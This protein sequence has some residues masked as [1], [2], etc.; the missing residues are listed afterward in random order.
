M[1]RNIVGL[2]IGV[3]VAVLILAGILLV[4]A[5]REHLDADKL[6]EVASA[7]PTA[8]ATGADRFRSAATMR[9]PRPK[10][11]LQ[12]PEV[13]LGGGDEMGMMRIG[14]GLS[15]QQI[16]AS[17]GPYHSYLANCQP[18]DGED[19]SGSVTF[20]LNV[21]CDGVVHGVEVTDDSLYEPEMIACLRDRLTYV[22]FPAHDLEDGMYFEYPLIFHPPSL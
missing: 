14:E 17:F 5:V 4:P 1:R 6:Q 7:V 21:G 20:E 10:K 8:G 15:P 16:N 22:E 9:K 2:V 19:H 11:C 12:A 3:V 13:D 18:V